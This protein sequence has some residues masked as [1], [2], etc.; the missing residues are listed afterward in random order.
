MTT[1]TLGER[2]DALDILDRWIHENEDAIAAAEGELPQFLIELLDQ[3]EGDFKEKARRVARYALGLDA[4]VDV[5]GDEIAR[6]QQRKRVRENAAKRLRERLRQQMVA[7]GMHDA[8]DPLVTVRLQ[9]GPPRVESTATEYDLQLQY[10]MTA[11]HNN[12]GGEEMRQLV[13]YI[14]AQY[15]PDKRAILA[16]HKAGKPLP[17]YFRVVP[18]DAQLRIR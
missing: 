8:S 14:P 7:A 2:L 13:R 4:E 16:E 15:E 11:D 9:Q 12:D 3:A 17:A 1:V 18:G 6:L 10:D 5:I